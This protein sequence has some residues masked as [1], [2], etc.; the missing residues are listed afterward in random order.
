MRTALESAP[1]ATMGA[2]V[3]CAGE[4]DKCIGIE[5]DRQLSL[6]QGTTRQQFNG[7]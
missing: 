7:L 5:C 3:G 4:L 2:I 1:R 6:G